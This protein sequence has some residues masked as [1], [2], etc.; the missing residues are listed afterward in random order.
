MTKIMVSVDGSLRDATMD[1]QQIIRLD[2]KSLALKETALPPVTEQPVICTALNYAQ[3]YAS[4]ESAFQLPPYERPPRRPVF[5]IKPPNTLTGHLGVVPCPDHADCIYSGGGLAVVIGRRAAR[6]AQREWRDYVAGYT[7]FNDFTLADDSYFRPPVV[8]RC[9]DGA[10]PVGPIV[11]AR[12]EV[13]DPHRLQITTSVNG[14]VRH[15][16]SSAD[17]R[18]SIPAVLEALTSFMTL[19]PG[20]AVVSG[21]PGDRPAV[22]PGDEV[23]V[24][25]EQLGALVNRIVSEQD[26]SAAPAPAHPGRP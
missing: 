19:E 18:L 14:E 12:E 13:A 3:H 16:A 4:L 25:I 10:G 7:I 22:R 11:V 26:Y 8:T 21:I 23:T 2:G 20:T 9:F 17:L 1:E 24:A 5:F 6:I 15:A